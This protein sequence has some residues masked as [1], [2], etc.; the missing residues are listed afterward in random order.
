[1]A[2]PRQNSAS[3]TCRLIVF[4]TACLFTTGV[5]TLSA[6]DLEWVT[7]ADPGNPP[8]R[9][10]FGAVAY[11]FQ[12]GKY[13]ITIAQYA[14][15]LNAVAR[16][17]AHGLENSEFNRS[18]RSGEPGSFVYTP[19]PGSEMKPMGSV[20]F[21]DAIRFAN[22][23]HNGCGSANTEHGAYNIEEL[24]AFAPREPGAQVWIPSEDEWYK[25]AYY[26]PEGKGGP[27]GGYWLYPTRSGNTPEFDEAGSLQPNQ[28]NYAPIHFHRWDG[29]LFR[30]ATDTLPVGSYPNSAS[31]YGTLDQGGNV[32]EWN[33]AIVFKT[34]RGLRGGC[35]VNTFEKMR[36]WVRAYVPPERCNFNHMPA[37]FRVARAVPAPISS[38]LRERTSAPLKTGSFR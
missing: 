2:S 11:E 10:G 36:S 31:Y 6:L 21:L 30:K 32:W 15:F 18:M 16:K 3:K 20:S 8:D 34:Q 35:V 27:P 9:T 22:W 19:P 23:M 12:I 14:E 29:F 24:G 33:E 7:V 4:T 28:A 17:P 38:N 25:A 13:E 1:M 37:G 5:A 26:Q